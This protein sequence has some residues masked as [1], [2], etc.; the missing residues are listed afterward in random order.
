VVC[1]DDLLG[2][3]VQSEAHVLRIGHRRVEIKIREVHSDEDG[4][5]R[6][7][8]GVEEQ[9]D[10]GEVRGW[11]RLV[12]WIIDAIAADGESGAM[13]L[14]FLRSE[15]ADDTTV[16]GPFVGRYLAFSDEETSI[17]ALQVSDSLEETTDIVSKAAFPHALCGGILDKM[18]V[19]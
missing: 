14:L 2:D 16:C 18:S 8:G 15:V 11:G 13:L 12:A 10:G 9:F 3:D 7:D 4:A 5:R 1:D 19:F 17:S 6:A